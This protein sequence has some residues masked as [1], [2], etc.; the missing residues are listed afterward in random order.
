MPIAYSLT[1]VKGGEV[2]RTY[3]VDRVKADLGRHAGQNDIVL[4]DPF[5]SN[6]HARIFSNSGKFFLEDLGSTNKTFVNGVALLPGKPV[7]LSSGMEFTLGKMVFQF[8]CAPSVGPDLSIKKNIPKNVKS[9]N[10]ISDYFNLRKMPQL[11][12]VS[13]G[14]LLWA[15]AVIVFLIIT[16]SVNR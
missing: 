16:N 4:N 9:F 12:P 10:R 11:S 13:L 6:K 7:I 5:I 2:N 3:K 1:I 14:I 15:I 8:K